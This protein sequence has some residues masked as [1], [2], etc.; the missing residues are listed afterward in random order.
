MNAR[1]T[2]FLCCLLTAA[3]IRITMNSEANAPA[4]P[5][6]GV[7]RELA[8]ARAATISDLHY[9]LRFE[10]ASGVAAIK[11]HADIR[12]RWQPS[13]APVILDFRD[14]D[15]NSQPREGKVSAVKIN[16][17]AINNAQQVNGHVVLPAAHFKAGENH[18]ALQFETA[19][20]AAGR[21][22]IR[23]QDRDDGSEY[24]Y[25]LFMPM[26][27][28]LAFPCFDQPDLKGR[29]TLEIK[30]PE[31]WKV[32]AN[33]NIARVAKPTGEPPLF[34]TSTFQETRPISTYLF[35]FATG[36]FVQIKDEQATALPQSYYVRQSQLKRAQ[37]ELPAVMELTRAGM[38]HYINFFG[39]E[40]PFTKYDQV[41][42]PGFAYGGMEHAGA[43]FLRE[44][45]VL[46][47][48]VPTKGDQL[49]RASLV[50]HELAHQWFGDLVTM[51]WFDDL[52]LKEGFANYMAGHAL[53]AIQP[54]GFDEREM[55]KRFYQRHKPDAYGIDST[56][57]TTPIYQ[58]VPN[59]KDAK[60][61][62]G[63]IVYEK[64]PSLL[65][66]LSFLIG[67]E[68]FKAG[69]QLFLREHAYGNAE[70]SDLIHAFER[71]S[72][73]PLTAWANAWVKQRGMPQVE[74]VWSCDAQGK[75]D[76]FELRQRDVLGEGHRWPIKTQLLLGY[77]D[78]TTERLPAQFDT[79]SAPV[80]AALGKPCPAFVF[81]ND[82][83]YGYGRFLLDAR[84]R[85]AVSER[86]ATTK[87]AF[88]RTLLWGALWEAVREA[89]MPPGEYLQLALNA[90]PQ[91]QDEDLTATLLN[92]ATTAY[93]SYLSER[94]RTALA[95]QFEALC[96]D[97]M[98]NAADL[99]LRIT[100][101]RAFRAIAA[102][103]AAR[104]QLKD[105]LAGKLTLPGIEIKPLDRWRLLTALLARQDEDAEA[106]L[107]AE[108]QRDAGDEGRKQA[109][110]A[111]AARADAATKQRYFHDYLQN[112]A[113]PEDWIEGSLG[114]FNVWNQSALTL[115]F[116]QPALAALP[117]VKRTRKI[118]FGLAW[119][120]AFIGGQQ[121]P[122]A[123][124]QVQ[125][126]LRAAKLDRDL[127]LKVLEVV[128]ELE[129]TVRIRQKY[130]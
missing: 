63:A 129:R 7:A 109:Y 54:L 11:G 82:E 126:F 110:L 47:R 33:A 61:A 72:K 5:A 9:K 38:R 71:S 10:I 36:P 70:W 89:E 122:E 32:A 79:A 77:A 114:S 37:A 73:Q 103:P 100:W 80:K 58:E 85:A 53:A 22:L 52:W 125:T 27:A 128:D 41:L 87:D 50:L 81:G 17:R 4:P 113:V 2:F 101:F 1:F 115:P 83:D 75:I 45:A 6:S 31:A 19:S 28:S 112:P 59:L 120:N 35:A 65:R 108:K 74:T 49:N 130:Q 102:T 44:D 20:A 76:R 34:T 56:K 64:A 13:P 26:D 43:T 104:L 48:T 119:L 66:A 84:S 117:Q 16:G 93:Q 21:P 68:N 42:L 24:L 95:L 118:F 60:S 29:F 92:H 106:L 15:A 23:Y 8:R 116:L 12:F 127:E 86:V 57:G 69:V 78:G 99:G 51:R 30:A 107:T 111:E 39:H 91:E 96:A 67:A 94:A 88:L 3:T 97:R 18:I 14:L 62:Y 25:T 121:S 124:A 98:Q 105:L 55:W 123:L 46:F 90:L 40:F